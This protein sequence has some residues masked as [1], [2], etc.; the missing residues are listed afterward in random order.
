M[1]TLYRTSATSDGGRA[2]GRVGLSEGGVYLSMALPQSM[3]GTGKGSNPEQLFA[4]GYASCYNQALLVVGGQRKVNVEKAE[5]VCTVELG[6][7]EGGFALSAELTVKIPGLDPA[8]ARELAEA[9]HD[10]C[11]YSKATHNNMPVTLNVA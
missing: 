4:M 9:A 8:Q 3:G 5:I 6:Q 2:S 1:K 11:P 10:M 7:D